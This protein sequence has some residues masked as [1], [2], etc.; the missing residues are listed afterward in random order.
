M[1]AME[2]GAPLRFALASLALLC[3]CHHAKPVPPTFHYRSQAHEWPL[4]KSWSSRLD[5]T[6]ALR[7][8]DAIKV[9]LAYA[10]TV[11]VASTSGP[12]EIAVM[13]FTAGKKPLAQARAGGTLTAPVPAGD[14]F[15]VTH[16]KTG[17]APGKVQLIASFV[18]PPAGEPPP[19]T[20]EAPAVTT[21]TSSTDPDLLEPGQP[22]APADPNSLS[23][24]DL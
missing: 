4:G 16:A 3:A 20:V 2:T 5:G 15:I 7:A 14:V 13:I 6:D 12:A 18:P 22:G 8:T 17:A 1:N 23:L 19:G 9:H 24:D 11:N 21:A 10:G